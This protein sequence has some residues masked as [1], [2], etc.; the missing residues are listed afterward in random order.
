VKWN[1][2]RVER[3]FRRATREEV[4]RLVT[5]GTNTLDDLLQLLPGV[6]PTDAIDALKQLGLVEKVARRAATRSTGGGATA[7]LL[8][9]C[10]PL[11]YDWRFEPTA[12]EMLLERALRVTQDG[13]TIAILGAPSVAE[14]AMATAVK[15]RV[16]LLD[17]NPFSVA[18]LANGGTQVV[19]LCGDLLRDVLPA[20][21]SDATI[22]DPPW[23]PEHIESFLWAGRQVTRL[24]GHVLLSLPPMGT[25]PGVELE[26][27]DAL[28]VAGE[29]GLSLVEIVP[30]AL[31]YLSPLFEWNALRAVGITD[32]PFCW[33]KG[34][35]AVFVVTG[36]N[37]R[38]RRDPGPEEA[39]SEATIDDVRIRT[40]L[41]H[42][43]GFADPTLRSL[44][45]SD[46]LPTV[47][48]RA[49]M[50]RRVHVWT[51]GN[52]VF[53]CEGSDVFAQLAAARATGLPTEKAVCDL[54]G[55]P[56][57]PRERDLVA[58]C[59]S[60]LEALVAQERSEMGLYREWIA[61]AN[62]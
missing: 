46:V 42:G 20:V 57:R 27:Q 10:H 12:R 21:N 45:P 14:W 35:L 48:R 37:Q 53:R 7:S 32:L 30:G 5:E 43:R 4:R 26:R 38:P 24:R 50:R 47:S 49:P 59:I 9:I 31:G 3:E 2:Q 60:Q 55:R 58:R 15:R 22:V 28:T 19:P 39:W 18:A 6:Y 33:R 11:D 1:R 8:P 51:S 40:R 56:L 54:I 41:N 44:T 62:S 17:R 36:I 29:M 34:D 13:S 52:R 25:R 16:L 61:T 23:Y